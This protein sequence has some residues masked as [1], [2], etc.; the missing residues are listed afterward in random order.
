M[1]TTQQPAAGFARAKQQF[2]SK[3]ITANGTKT[4][5]IEAGTGD[6]VLLLHGGGPIRDRSR[7]RRTRATSTWSRSSRR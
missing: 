6:P 5:Y 1:S 4:H 2:Q 3:Y 7:T